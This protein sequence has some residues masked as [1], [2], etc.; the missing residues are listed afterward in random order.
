MDQSGQAEQSVPLA[1]TEEV[2][3][4]AA[5][6]AEKLVPQ[7]INFSKT[8]IQRMKD[9]EKVFTCKIFLLILISH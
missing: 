5:V 6:V 7:F 3:R 1:T 2:Y 4:L 9:L 8:T